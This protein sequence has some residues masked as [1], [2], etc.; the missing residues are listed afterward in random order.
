MDM[1]K[2]KMIA[3][4]AH[5]CGFLAVLLGF[6]TLNGVIPLSLISQT[7]AVLGLGVGSGT[8]YLGHR[9]L[10]VLNGLGG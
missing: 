1:A 3:Y 6:L 2:L 8:L 5:V 4:S 9:L 7:E 10:K